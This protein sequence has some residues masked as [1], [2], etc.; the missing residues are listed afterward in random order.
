M[1]T[2]CGVSILLCCF[3]FLNQSPARAQISEQTPR[4]VERRNSPLIGV[5]DDRFINEIIKLLNDAVITDLDAKVSLESTEIEHGRVRLR[6][7]LLQNLRVGLRLN[8]RGTRRLIDLIGQ[9]YGNG[10]QI[11]AQQN[12]FSQMLEILKLGIFNRLEV[13]I[14]LKELRIRDLSVNADALD[15]KGLR[16]LANARTP[17][18]PAPQRADTFSQLMN[19]LQR[20]TISRVE[21][22][23][24][25]EKLAARRLKLQLQGIALEEFGIDLKLLRQDA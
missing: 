6:G 18:N 22:H 25:L 19:L 21:A 14:R 10:H 15:V 12:Q 13:G 7:V 8:A 2:F 5:N 4:I 9:R 11:S 23:A 24:G 20:T 17:H 3:S 1:K 16:L